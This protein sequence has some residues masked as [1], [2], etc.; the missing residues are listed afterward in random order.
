MKK[1][2]IFIRILNLKKIFSLEYLKIKN[3]RENII[4]NFFS[5]YLK[6]KMKKK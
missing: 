4:S 2:F 3:K 1:I 5:F 6:Y